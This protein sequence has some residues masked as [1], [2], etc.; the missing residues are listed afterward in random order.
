VVRGLA[1][2]AA[3]AELEE[4]RAH[5]AACAACGEASA[6]LEDAW[7]ELGKW[8]APKAP[9]DSAA[10]LATRLA[11][12]TESMQRSLPSRPRW[13]WLVA[14]ALV[15]ALAGFGGTA[16]RHPPSEREP[17]FLLLLR[18]GPDA[19]DPGSG[20][21]HERMVAEYSAWRSEMVRRGVLRASR[22]L[23][24]GTGLVLRGGSTAV[25]ARGVPR[26]GGGEF[27]SGFFLVE[28]ENLDAAEAIARTS[29]HLEYGG[30]IEIRPIVEPPK[31]GRR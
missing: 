2:E 3:R 9:A 1:G 10:R 11:L 31:P 23:D 12:R 13:P 14:A 21:L 4:A 28:A 30:S 24:A 18:R 29:P 19:V 6:Q 8:Q 5:V 15:G 17:T 22:L 26:D 27:V 25:A 16:I 20:P 7:R